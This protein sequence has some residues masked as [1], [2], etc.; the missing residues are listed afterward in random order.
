MPPTRTANL[1]GALCS[2]VN[3]L[4]NRH[5]RRH[6]NQ[7]DSS[8]AALNVIGF[9]RGCS[10][11]RLSQ[12]LRLSHPATVRLVDRLEED[13]LVESRTGDDRRSVALFLTALGERRLIEILHCR[14]ESLEDVLQ[15]LSLHERDTLA[16]LLGKLLKSQVSARGDDDYICRL[17]NGDLCPPERC[18]VHLAAEALAFPG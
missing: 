17:C 7:T 13:G 18:P 15:P 9:Y 2:L 1:L 8:A 14:A 11:L 4:Q 5:L 6:P 16:R 3:S 12:A 10:N